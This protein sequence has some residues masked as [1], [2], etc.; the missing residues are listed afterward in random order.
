MGMMSRRLAAI[1][2]ALLI[3]TAPAAYGQTRD[4]A[5]EAK[6]QY[7]IKS[8]EK[9]QGVKFIRNGRQYSAAEAA[10]HLRLKLG[11]AG[12]RVKTA[13]DFI[14]LCGSRSYLSGEPYAL[15]FF[16]GTTVSS[17]SFFRRRLN[18]YK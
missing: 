4:A 16:D 13:E 2:S 1:L 5:E 11:R 14:V 9:L 18:E 8:V 17:E 6:I 7:L 12:P 10:G 15:M 3:V